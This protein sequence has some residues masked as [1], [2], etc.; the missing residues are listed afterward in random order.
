MDYAKIKYYKAKQFQLLV[1]ILFSLSLLGFITKNPIHTFFSFLVLSFIVWF[2]WRPGEPPVLLFALIIQWISVTIKPLYGN[3]ISENFKDLYHNFP[4]M[5]NMA[6]YLNLVGL[7]FLSLGIFLILRKE[8]PVT[9]SAEEL[10]AIK[11]KNVIILYILFS[12]LIMLLLSL[13]HAIPGIFQAVYALSLL[14]LSI[15]YLLLL[16]A[17]HNNP[18]KWIVYLIVLYEFIIGFAGYFSAFKD[19][20]F[21]ILLALFSA[22]IK[23]KFSQLIIAVIIAL[24]LFRIAVIWTDIKFEYRYFLSGGERVQKVTVDRNDALSRF[25]DLFMESYVS[26]LSEPRE[27]LIN[28]ISYIDYFS[29]VLSHVPREENHTFGKIWIDAILHIFTPRILFPNKESINDSVHLTKYTGKYFPDLEKGVSYSLGYTGDS[30]I[31]FGPIF[32][33]LPIFFMGILIGLVY[34][35]IIYITS[36]K[37]FTFSLLIPIFRIIFDLGITPK[38]FMG[39]LIMYFLVIFFLNKFLLKKIQSFIFN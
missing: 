34:K 37:I 29:G 4:E 16:I 5:I 22:K 1:G 9:I 23:L 6:F 19:I 31:D 20:V 21:V 28:R 30:Y 25:T 7:L 2:T 32:M 17:F 8:R 10:N 35:R 38:I 24:F 11:A 3:L 14:K 36:S 26:D 18:V 13:R 39:L 27:Q 12:L 15:L 33:F